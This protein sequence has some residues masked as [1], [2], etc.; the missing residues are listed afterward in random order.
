MQR[1]LFL[2]FATAPLGPAHAWQQRIVKISALSDGTILADGRKI[3]L[4]TLD[5]LL[6]K[7]RLDEGAVWYFRE[8]ALSEPTT[9]AMEAIKLVV[10]HSL[11]VSM[12]TRPDFTDYVDSSGKSRPRQ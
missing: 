4:A 12:S 9:Q 5:K 8:N 2:F 6:A 1:R 10:K 7:L 11:P 3:D